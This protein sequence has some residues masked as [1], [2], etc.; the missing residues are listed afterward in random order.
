MGQLLAFTALES[1]HLCSWFFYLSEIPTKLEPSQSIPSPSFLEKSNLIKHRLWL[2]T[3]FWGLSE[4]LSQ[5]EQEHRDEWDSW[6]T[7]S[8][9]LTSVKCN[10]STAVTGVRAGWRCSTMATGAQC[11]MTTGIWWTPTWCASSWTA[12]W[13][14]QWAAALTLDK[15]QGS[16]CWTMWTAGEMRQSWA[17]ATV[18]AGAFTTV[19]TTRTWAS[20]AEVHKDKTAFQL[21]KQWTHCLWSLYKLN[22][23]LL[24]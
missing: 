23:L 9:V 10:W 17:S 12:A 16:S 3:W 2:G 20:P 14:W 7:V 11:A 4:W 21:R 19:T 22:F 18:W 15:A 13:L 24:F 5:C 1:K 8:P 6:L